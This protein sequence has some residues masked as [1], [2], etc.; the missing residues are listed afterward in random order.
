LEGNNLDN[1]QWCCTDSYRGLRPG[2]AY[3][4]EAQEVG[5]SNASLD[6]IRHRRAKT[7]LQANSGYHNDSWASKT[8][9][10]DLRY[11]K[12]GTTELSEKGNWK[13]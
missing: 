12:G 6:E 2:H 13:S 11:H 5:I 9:I 10:M 8:K 4:W 1:Q 7:K 3:T